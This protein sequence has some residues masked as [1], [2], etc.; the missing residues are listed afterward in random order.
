[1][2]RSHRQTLAVLILY[3]TCRGAT[4]PPAWHRVSGTADERCVLLSLL[5]ALRFRKMRPVYS[6]AQPT[7]IG[8]LSRHYTALAQ[9]R[10]PNRNELHARSG[11]KCPKSRQLRKSVNSTNR[12]LPTFAIDLLTKATSAAIGQAVLQ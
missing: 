8:A 12:N 5:R 9:L 4:L 2:V 11:E 6:G 7:A 3:S 1:M 10:S